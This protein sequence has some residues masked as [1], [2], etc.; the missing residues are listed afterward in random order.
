M[1]IRYRG[2]T[3][4][5]GERVVFLQ[6][7]T[8]ELWSSLVLTAVLPQLIELFTKAWDTSLVNQSDVY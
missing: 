6:N 1:Q 4:L 3:Y 7:E 2:F 8:K 5:S